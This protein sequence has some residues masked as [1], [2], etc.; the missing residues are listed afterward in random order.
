MSKNKKIHHKQF[1]AIKNFST[2]KSV[3]LK[4]FGGD[5]SASALCET[6]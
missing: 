2:M 1:L 6:K 3:P 5:S 4:L